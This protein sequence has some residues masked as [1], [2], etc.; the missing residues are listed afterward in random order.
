MSE[1][2]K[3]TRDGF[4]EA[5]I[6]LG[7][8]NK[9]VVVLTA[10]LGE[11][12]RAHWFKEKYPDRFIEV[13]VAEENMIGVATGLA[14]TNK[15]PFATSYATFIVN[16]TLGPTRVACYSN[17]NIKIIGHHTGFSA[18]F[19]GATHQALE[20]ITIMT[21]LPNM[22]VVSPC[23]Y[24]QTQ[25]AT[26]AIARH[27]GPCYLRVSKN[28]TANITTKNTPFIIGKAQLLK[29]GSDLAIITTGS[30]T[31]TA[32][33]IA[34]ELKEQYSIEILNIH[35][36]KP[37]DT[38]AILK[39]ANKTR[40]ILTLEEHQKI[41]GLGSMV[42]SVLAQ[43]NTKTVFKILGVDDSFG[44]SGTREELLEKHHLD[45]NSIIKEVEQLMIE[46]AMT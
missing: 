33:K 46:K 14:L 16:N 26:L 10:D 30:I 43:E 12:T 18:S 20:D 24:N 38:K 27:N 3:S 25:Q 17:A 22:T 5:L 28:K 9:E 6:K 13:G 45:K 31:A 11:S 34:D 29:E 35:T 44:G 2:L 23:D 19:D 39:T 15:I 37:L 32:V 4:G 36:I 8:S 40:A 42:A 7:E 41:G 21:S 1:E